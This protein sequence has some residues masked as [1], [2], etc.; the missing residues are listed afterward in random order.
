MLEWGPLLPY[1]VGRIAYQVRE[2]V[3]ETKREKDRGIKIGRK[4]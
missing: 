4:K 2:R 1:D 3:R